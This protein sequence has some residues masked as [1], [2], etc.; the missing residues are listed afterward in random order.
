M[1]EAYVISFLACSMAEPLRCKP[2]EILTDQ[3]TPLGCAIV[4]QQLAAAWQNADHQAGRWFV[5]TS[6]RLRCVAPA[7]SKTAV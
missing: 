5:D 7:R 6:Q 4:S 1:F 3:I 2:I